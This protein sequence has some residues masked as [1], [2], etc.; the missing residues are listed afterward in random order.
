MAKAKHTEGPWEIVEG[1]SNPYFEFR[2]RAGEHLIAFVCAD[3][4]GENGLV[5]SADAHLIA[6]APDLFEVVDSFD[7]SVDAEGD[8]W[9]MIRLSPP[10]QYESCG[11][12][13]NLGRAPTEAR[14]VA[15]QLETVRQA[16]LKKAR[17]E[18]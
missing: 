15:L 14:K 4:D 18:Q 5:P 6:A 7:L 12:M 9:F 3:P 8:L 1:T 10:L 11:A 2:V 13:F 16:A 17:G